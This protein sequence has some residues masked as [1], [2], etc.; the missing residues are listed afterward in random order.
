[1][2]FLID[3]TIC[4]T[5]HYVKMKKIIWTNDLSLD[6]LNKKFDLVMREV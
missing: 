5:K 2:I 6:E 4:Q 3:T 1:M